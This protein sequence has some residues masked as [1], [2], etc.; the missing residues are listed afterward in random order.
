MRLVT[1]EYRLYVITRKHF[2]TYFTCFTTIIIKMHTAHL[3]IQA[4][5]IKLHIYYLT[6]EVIATKAMVDTCGK[7]LGD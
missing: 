4:K 7:W 3:A 5:M 1:V 6:A 2:I